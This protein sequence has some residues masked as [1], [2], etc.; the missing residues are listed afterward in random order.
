MQKIAICGLILLCQGCVLTAREKPF[1]E[2]A[3]ITPGEAVELAKTASLAD[4]CQGTKNWR[5]D[6]IKSASLNEI[7][8]RGIDT[9]ECYYTGMALTP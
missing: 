4:L 5:P 7:K 1:Y 6:A 2:R 8:K 3:Y 9:R